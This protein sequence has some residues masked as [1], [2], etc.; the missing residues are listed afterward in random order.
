MTS[1]FFSSV[2]SS[3]PA[4]VRSALEVAVS[5]HAHVL[6]LG[7]TG[8]GKSR[9]AE[10]IHRSGA[11]KGGPFVSVN[12]AS[13]HD[14]TFESELFGHEKGAFTGA[15]RRRIGLLET[16]DG[17]TLF[18]DEVGELSPR[19]QCRLL[20]F[21]QSKTFTPV[22][23]TRRVAVNTRIIVATHRD[24]ASEV[25]LGSFREDLFHRLRVV[26][27]RM[28]SLMEMAAD[29][30][31]ILH[32]CLEEVC[33]EQSVSVL[34]ISEEAAQA[35]EHHA[36]PG[37]YRELRHVLEF[38]VIRCRG[39]VIE[40]I[41]LPDWFFQNEEPRSNPERVPEREGVD[42]EVHVAERALMEKGLASAVADFERKSICWAL[43]RCRGG[44]SRTAR[45]LKMS[46]ATL[47]RRIREH[48]LAE[49]LRSENP[50]PG[51]WNSPPRG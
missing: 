27:V 22:G 4:S 46:K 15:D 50:L 2:P 3:V 41:D 31:A 33:A 7:P 16:A 34:R 19:L 51:D 38:A 25:R 21:L 5:S 49:P 43:Y 40:R 11:R 37:N 26:M 14:G 23:S 8:S 28:P 17:G 13:L 20:E 24:L 48:G 10:A 45:E 47:I 29:F 44:I 39:G 36:W 12:L 9:M 18:L 1:L 32:G 35:L 42:L 30:D 6:L